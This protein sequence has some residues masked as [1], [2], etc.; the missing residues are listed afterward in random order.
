MLFS[1]NVSRRISL[2]AVQ[3]RQ[4]YSPFEGYLRKKLHFKSETEQTARHQARTIRLRDGF[5]PDALMS[6]ST[7]VCG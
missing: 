6:S 1:S 7:L 4:K 5:Y 2:L 3:L